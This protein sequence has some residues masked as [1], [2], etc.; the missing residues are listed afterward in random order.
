MALASGLCLTCRTVP[1]ALRAAFDTNHT[2]VRYN[3]ETG[4]LYFATTVTSTSL[5]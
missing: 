3:L 4:G 2:S 5:P 1:V